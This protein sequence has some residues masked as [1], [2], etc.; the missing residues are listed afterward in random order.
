MAA[1]KA[2]SKIRLRKYLIIN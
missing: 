2:N 1:L